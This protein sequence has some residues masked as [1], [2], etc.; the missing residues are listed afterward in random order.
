[1][2]FTRGDYFGV[3]CWQL[4]A[5]GWSADVDW[6]TWLRIPIGFSAGTHSTERRGKFPAWSW[7]LD[8]NAP[9]G[10]PCRLYLHRWGWWATLS[11]WPGHGIHRYRAHKN[12][13]GKWM[14]DAVPEKGH[15]GW[16]TVSRDSS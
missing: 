13:E 4:K 5:D 10:E 14:D 7:C 6:T 2:K 15:W 11:L 8:L 12:E 16:L 9:F 1:M 3:P